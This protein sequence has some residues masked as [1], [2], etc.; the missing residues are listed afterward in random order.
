MTAILP[1]SDGWMDPPSRK[2]REPWMRGAIHCGVNGR[3]MTSI[4]S[5]VA[6]ITGHAH[7]CHRSAS[8]FAAM[9][10]ATA[11]AA[12]P[13]S[14][15]SRKKA[16]PRPACIAAMALALYSTARPN[17]TSTAVTSVSAF[18]STLICHRSRTWRWPG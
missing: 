2:R 13:V 16:L 12:T 7:F 17:A 10:N 5:S 9:A 15:R 3:M 4:T 6:P 1:N 11:P 8:S 14:C 18:A